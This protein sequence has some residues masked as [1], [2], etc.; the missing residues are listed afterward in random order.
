M[1]HKLPPLAAKYSRREEKERKTTKARCTFRL[2]STS[3]SLQ[4]QVQIIR[5]ISS[6]Y[7]NQI[8]GAEKH[9][10]IKLPAQT[11]PLLSLPHYRYY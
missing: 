11:L 1:R 6:T 9:A 7:M 10:T 4:Q 3:I 5:I 8:T 2:I